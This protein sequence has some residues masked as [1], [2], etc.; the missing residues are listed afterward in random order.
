MH[1]CPPVYD[2]ISHKVIRSPKV[3]LSVFLFSIKFSAVYSLPHYFSSLSS[4]FSHVFRNSPPRCGTSIG[5]QAFLFSFAS[6]PWPNSLFP[7][8]SRPTFPPTSP[9]LPPSSLGF[10]TIPFPFSPPLHRP[11][12]HSLREF[13]HP[14]G[15]ASYIERLGTRSLWRQATTLPVHL[16]REHLIPL[17]AYKN[18]EPRSGT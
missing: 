9:P 13:F 2:I 16:N 4:S 6:F 1:F 10:N 11:L 12:S 14:V 8:S 18:T 3:T 17:F 7:S 5:S 15:S